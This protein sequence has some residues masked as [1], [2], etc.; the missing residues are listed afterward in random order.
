MGFQVITTFSYNSGAPS[1]GRDV[2]QIWL[3]DRACL[4]ATDGWSDYPKMELVL[5][6]QHLP[7][8]VIE[9]RQDL[10]Q[11]IKATGRPEAQKLRLD[12]FRYL[13]PQDLKVGDDSVPVTIRYGRWRFSRTVT[14]R[15]RVVKL[16]VP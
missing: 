10:A 15:S 1:Q 9:A 6:P 16:I 12:S 3:A 5:H 13:L 11:E 14:F 8:E 4:V 7:R 2:L